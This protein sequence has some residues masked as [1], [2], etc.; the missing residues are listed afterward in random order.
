MITKRLAHINILADDLAA[1]E[2]F[3]CGVLGMERGFDFIK[4]GKLWGFYVKAGNDTYIEVFLNEGGPLDSSRATM[5]H[6][7]LEV[8]DIDSAIA[9]I[10]ERG[11]QIGDKKLGGDN[12][13]QAWMNDPTGIPIEI[14]QYTPNSSHFTG[15][16]CPVTW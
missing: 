10:R 11:W 5:R 8:E 9:Q 6:I 3:Y 16:P 14:M 4:N 2:Q 13:W 7:C 12:A 15:V 1:A